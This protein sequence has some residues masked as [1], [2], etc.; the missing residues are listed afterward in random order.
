MFFF[1]FAR[2]QGLGIDLDQDRPK[3]G[4]IVEMSQRIDEDDAEACAPFDEIDMPC[5]CTLIERR[6]DPA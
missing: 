3:S 4:V 1:A 2:A 5:S 6:D